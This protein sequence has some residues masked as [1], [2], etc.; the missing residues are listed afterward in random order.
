M[1]SRPSVVRV[2]VL[3]NTAALLIST[4][5][6]WWSR[7][8][9]P[10]NSR[11]ARGEDRSTSASSTVTVPPEEATA[12]RASSPRIPSRQIMTTFWARLANTVAVAR[13]SPELASVTMHV[14]ASMARCPR[15]GTLT[16]CRIRRSSG[17]PPEACRGG[18][19]A[20]LLSP[21]RAAARP[22]ARGRPPTC[23]VRS[24]SS[25]PS[26]LR[27][28]RPSGMRRIA[29]ILPLSSPRSTETEMIPFGT[30]C[31]GNERLIFASA[32]FVSARTR[33]WGRLL[34]IPRQ[35]HP[36]GDESYRAMH[37]V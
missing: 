2:L 24:S 21:S 13:P 36:E 26:S 18:Q 17:W 4:S 11:I 20:E 27:P 5:S 15:S 8:K 16:L 35:G 31:S 29:R 37:S 33:A 3:L 12:A 28:T 23:D 25:P 1:T 9:S 22:T 14:L 19:A 34:V 7:S 10:T 30:N 32:S 6:R